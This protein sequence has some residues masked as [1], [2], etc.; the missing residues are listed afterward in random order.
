LKGSDIAGTKNGF[1]ELSEIALFGN[2][3]PLQFK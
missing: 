1:E 2:G 3:D